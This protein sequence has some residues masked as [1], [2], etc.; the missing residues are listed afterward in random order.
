MPNR[1]NKSKEIIT[2]NIPDVKVKK[3]V[4]VKKVVIGD[5]TYDLSKCGSEKQE[6]FASLMKKAVEVEYY[7]K[8]NSPNF[9]VRGYFELDDITPEQLE[10]LKEFINIEENK[11][12]VML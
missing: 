6:V 3:V 9:N 12:C 4:G 10:L 2:A 8:V 1:W 11:S 5:T 7:H